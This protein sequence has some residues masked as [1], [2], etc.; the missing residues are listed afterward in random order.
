MIDILQSQLKTT[1]TG[2]EKI[3]T[4]REFLQLLI[5]KI[6]YDNGYFKNLTFTGGTA[7]RILYKTRRFSEDLDFSLTS[8]NHYQFESFIKTLRLNLG[9]S[10]FL[11]DVIPREVKTVEAVE[12]RFRGLLYRLGLS[13]LKSQKLMI[14]LEIDTNPPKGYAAEVSLVNEMAFFF[15]ATHFDLSSLYATK[16]HACF[17]RKYTKGR[18]FYDLIWYLG[19][20][21]VPNFTVLN[22]AIKQ[23]E[24]RDLKINENNLAEFLLDRLRKIDLNAARKDVERFLVDKSELR[25]L[26]SQMIEQFI[27]QG[28]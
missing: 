11:A 22:N 28:V 19:R 15:T 21:T 26:D 14:K 12:L 27:K 10:G 4:A 7:L 17:Y 25:L 13:K 1:M 23:T 16:L 9:Q 6:I 18:D 3:N 8:R 5:L 20:K 24:G 2:E